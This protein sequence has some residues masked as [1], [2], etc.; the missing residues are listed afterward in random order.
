MRQKHEAKPGSANQRP[1]NINNQ[2]PDSLL[3]Q[4][5]RCP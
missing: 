1:R 4:T 5:A 2:E 3:N